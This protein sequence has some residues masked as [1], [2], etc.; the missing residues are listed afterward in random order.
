MGRHE[1]RC[2]WRSAAHLE[3]L[4]PLA[5]ERT[6]AIHDEEMKTV[7]RLI[8]ERPG[9]ASAL[10]IGRNGPD[11]GWRT[12][13]HAVTDGPGYFPA[14]PDRA[15]LLLASGA[16]PNDADTRRELLVAWRRDRGAPSSAGC[17]EER[18]GH[19]RR[20]GRDRFAECREVRIGTSGR[21]AHPQSTEVSRR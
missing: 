13:F 7:R 2:R 19:R 17:T 12:P 20:V 14:G 3:Y 8:G 4:D 21:W 18:W 16:D 5:L 15:A 10:M 6:A 1:V 9:L 11:G